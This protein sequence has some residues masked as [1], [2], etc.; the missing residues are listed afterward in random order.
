MNIRGAC[1]ALVLLLA[2]APNSQAG[3]DAI[4]REMKK[5]Q[6]AW[7]EQSVESN[8]VKDT[9]EDLKQNRLKIKGNTLQYQMKA[10]N[11][12]LVIYGT[13]KIVE[14]KGKLRK[15]NA[16]YSLDPDDPAGN[17]IPQLAEWLDDDT[18]RVCVPDFSS[19]K[20]MLERP[21]NFLATKGSGQSVATFKREKK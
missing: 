16:T 3:D 15:T 7:I 19:A 17:I 20:T 2:F 10:L 21:T 12:K 1:F 6:G 18:F 13:F 4:A 11:D 9:G 14:V 5:L 8:G